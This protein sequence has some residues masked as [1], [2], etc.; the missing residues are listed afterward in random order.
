MGNVYSVCICM[1][2]YVVYVTKLSNINWAILVI[3]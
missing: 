3:R 2:V 1:Y